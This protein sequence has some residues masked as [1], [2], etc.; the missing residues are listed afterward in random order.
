MH[1]SLKRKKFTVQLCTFQTAFNDLDRSAALS[2]YICSLVCLVFD[3]PNR[4][5]KVR[6]NRMNLIILMQWRRGEYL[7]RF[8]A[9]RPAIPD[10][11]R[12]LYLN[13]I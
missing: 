4:P 8:G 3:A 10:P 13:N 5:Q 2:I 11:R 1:F 9:I 7:P 6:I 12:R